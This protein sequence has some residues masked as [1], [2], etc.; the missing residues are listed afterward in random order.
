MSN[1]TFPIKAKNGIDGNDN[2]NA[3][4]ANAVF[5]IPLPTPLWPIAF[6]PA[7]KLVRPP[8]EPFPLAL[9]ILEV[10][11]VSGVLLPPPIPGI[12]DLKSIDFIFPTSFIPLDQSQIAAPTANAPFSILPT[13]PSPS[14]NSPVTPVSS[15]YQWL[16]FSTPIVK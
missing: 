16:N 7:D 2:N 9:S 13:T 14:F 4:P 3:G 15:W 1:L 5:K 8:S 10:S 11:G 6:N 12:I